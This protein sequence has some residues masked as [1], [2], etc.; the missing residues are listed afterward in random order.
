MPP[1]AFVYFRLSRSWCCY[2][3]VV[4]DGKN[5]AVFTSPVLCGG[6]GQVRGLCGDMDGSHSGD[7]LSRAG[8]EE[9][10]A[11]FAMSYGDCQDS[12]TSTSTSSVDYT[13]PEPC[14]LDPAVSSL[15]LSLSSG[16]LS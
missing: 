2:F 3:G 9:H 15:K 6:C 12:T 1:S 13:Q 8:I 16:A 4:L 5:F 14:S 11:V 7:F 10:L